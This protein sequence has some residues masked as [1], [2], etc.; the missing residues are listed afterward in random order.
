M[1]W[2]SALGW[3]YHGAV[4]GSGPLLRWFEANRRALPWRE[5]PRDPYR[6]LV[7]EV[8]LQQTQVDRV[9]PRFRRFIE[10]FPDTGA[11]AAAPEESVLEA[12]S[13][14]GYYGRAR[15]L[16]AA[17]RAIEAGGGRFPRTADALKR[18]PGIGEYTAAAVASLAF[19]EPVPVL[20]GNVLRVGARVLA[21]DVLARSAAGRRRIAEWVRSLMEDGPPGAVNEA[22]MELGATV[23]SRTSPQCAACPLRARCAGFAS[24][25]PEGWPEARKVREPEQV[26]WAAVMVHDPAGRILL[27]R[28]EEGSILRGLWLPPIVAIGAPEETLSAARSLAAVLGF[29]G[30]RTAPPVRHTIAHRRITVYPVLFDGPA[31]GLPPGHRWADPENPGLPTSSLL[32]KLVRALPGRS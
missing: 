11:L 28:I 2:A 19:G 7:S 15:R 23:C 30:G 22:L 26:R 29:D 17:A 21:L 1:R 20:D 27:R 12:W 4:W 3:G 6:V 16:H 9:V 31:A 14:L 5:E 8:M 25:R 13:G 18:L 32:S 10:R 24:G